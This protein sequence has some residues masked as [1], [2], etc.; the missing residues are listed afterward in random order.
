MVT[1]PRTEATTSAARIAI[2]VTL[3]P[4]WSAPT[5]IAD[6][7]VVPYARRASAE[8][9]AGCRRVAVAC[10]RSAAKPAST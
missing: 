1:P 8:R 3:T 9:W 4:I 2:Q 10:T 5:S 7:R 6:T